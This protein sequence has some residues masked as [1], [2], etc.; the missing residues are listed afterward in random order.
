MWKFGGVKMP[1]MG[2]KSGPNGPLSPTSREKSSVPPQFP[3]EFSSDFIVMCDG[4]YTIQDL[5]GLWKQ[6]IPVTWVSF[7]LSCAVESKCVRPDRGWLRMVS[8]RIFHTFR[9]G[10]P[11]FNRLSASSRPRS[12]L[13]VGAPDCWRFVWSMN[14]PGQP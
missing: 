8:A 9:F 10:A 5:L 13:Q 11:I 4:T 14:Y 1:P 6:K 3:H 12:R 2:N 7:F